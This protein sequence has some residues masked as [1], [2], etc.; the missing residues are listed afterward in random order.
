MD[1][2]FP[3][4]NDIDMDIQDFDQKELDDAVSGRKRKLEKQKFILVEKPKV[5]DLDEDEV[6]INRA[7][8]TEVVFIDDDEESSDKRPRVNDAGAAVPRHQQY[9]TESEIENDDGSVTVYLRPR[10]KTEHDTSPSLYINPKYQATEAPAPEQIKHEFKVKHEVKPEPEVKVKP[11]PREEPVVQPKGRSKSQPK[12]R[13]AQTEGFVKGEN[14]ELGSSSSSGDKAQLIAEVIADIT[15][16]KGKG[17]AKADESPA[18]DEPMHQF[19][20]PG[21]FNDT[22]KARTSGPP[23]PTAGK[24]KF[25]TAELSLPDINAHIDLMPPFSQSEST[26][27]LQVGMGFLNG[28]KKQH[29]FGLA[30]HSVGGLK[31]VLPLVRANTSSD[32]RPQINSGGLLSSYSANISFK[33]TYMVMTRVTDFISKVLSDTDLTGD[34][35]LKSL[36]ESLRVSLIIDPTDK[37]V[38]TN[39]GLLPGA[40]YSG[41]PGKNQISWDVHSV[42]GII[43]AGFE[44]MTRY[45]NFQGAC[46]RIGIEAE[47]I[48]GIERDKIIS[49]DYDRFGVM[50]ALIRQI[51]ALAKPATLNPHLPMVPIDLHDLK[52]LTV[53]FSATEYNSS[54]FPMSADGL[55]LK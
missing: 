29:N 18:F 44:L 32:E 53:N 13:A 8:K 48:Q 23:P 39:H 47:S 21:K 11:E 27:P 1:Y 54:S 35:L 26:G 15:K 34:G 14:S 49:I 3:R 22:F 28:A 19:E 30:T 10:V 5:Y 41:P 42:L 45:T 2:E 43:L 4:N 17:K 36:L 52:N 24:M 55:S 9:Y 50:Q 51:L 37:G 6:P 46:S 33:D 7:R 12:K 31:A 25:D 16:D 20:E 38:L 40:T